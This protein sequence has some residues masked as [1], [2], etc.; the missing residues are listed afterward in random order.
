MEISRLALFF[1][2]FLSISVHGGQFSSIIKRG[3]VDLCWMRMLAA[4][5]RRLFASTEAIEE[6]RSLTKATLSRLIKIGWL[7][8]VNGSFQ[9]MFWLFVTNEMVSFI[10]SYVS[11]CC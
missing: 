10:N 2:I 7:L 4:C 1:V 3:L 6:V 5:E 11:G 8:F 9:N